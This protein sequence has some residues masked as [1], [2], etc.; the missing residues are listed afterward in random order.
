[1]YRTLNAT[2]GFLAGLLIA[3]AIA[4]VMNGGL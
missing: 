3:F 2:L 1:M 4:A